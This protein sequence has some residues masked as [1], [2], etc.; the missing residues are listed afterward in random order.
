[1]LSKEELSDVFFFSQHDN[2]PAQLPKLQRQPRSGLRTSPSGS[3]F[4]PDQSQIL[5]ATE[6]VSL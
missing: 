6:L 5:N 1:M 3:C 4:G 2:A